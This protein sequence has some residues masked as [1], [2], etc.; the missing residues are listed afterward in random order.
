LG[1]FCAAFFGIYFYLSQKYVSRL[2][3]WSGTFWICLGNFAAFTLLLLKQ[4]SLSF[5][6]DLHILT[7]LLGIAIFS[8]LLPIYLV[9]KSLD[10]LNVTQ[11]SLLAVFEPI[12]TVLLGCMTLGE[13]ISHYQTVGIF[14]II[15]SVLLI[16]KD[17]KKTF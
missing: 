7:Y 14:L 9:F 15:S 5:R 2:H 4:S 3:I 13:N 16:Q 8:T 11:A 17:K 6:F 12:V 1:V 10:H